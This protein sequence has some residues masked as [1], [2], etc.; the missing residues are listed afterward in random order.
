MTKGFIK[1][2]M[3][4]DLIELCTKK[5]IKKTGKSYNLIVRNLGSNN[6]CDYA[7]VLFLKNCSAGLAYFLVTKVVSGI[8][9]VSVICDFQN[10]TCGLNKHKD[11]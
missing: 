2:W 6:S 5:E 3:A 10:I 8:N 7:V 11:N 1:F 4:K 9:K